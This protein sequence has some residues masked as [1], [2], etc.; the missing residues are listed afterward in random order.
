M[1]RPR[2]AY[3]CKLRRQS[4]G[5]EIRNPIAHFCTLSGRN[6]KRPT[7]LFKMLAE[8]IV[9]ANGSSAKARVAFRN[10]LSESAVQDWNE[11]AY[12]LRACSTQELAIILRD[13]PLKATKAGL[14]QTATPGATGCF[15]HPSPGIDE[16]VGPT[17]ESMITRQKLA[18]GAQCARLTQTR[19]A[20]CIETM[21]Q[22]ISTCKALC[23]QPKLRRA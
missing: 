11:N 16:N 12:R 9:S 15:A 17:L 21:G 13:R 10:R 7:Q 22:H 4:L 20:H 8:S 6:D 14:R 19:E 3:G 23:S 5:P 18:T 1:H 2:F